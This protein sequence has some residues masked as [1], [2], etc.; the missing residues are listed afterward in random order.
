MIP[1]VPIVE[2]ILL[3]L[4]DFPELNSPTF[5]PDTLHKDTLYLSHSFGVDAICLRS[6]LEDEVDSPESEFVR[7]VESRH[8][9]S[10]AISICN[11][12]LG[13]GLLALSSTNQLAGVELDFRTSSEIP[14]P[15]PKPFDES[16]G[17]SLL[18]AKSM[19]FDKLVT[20]PAFNPKASARSLPEYNRP[21]QTISPQHLR[22]IGGVISQIRKRVETIRS[23]SQLIENR[24]DLQLKEYQR[25]IKLLKEARDRVESLKASGSRERAERLLNSHAVLAT[26]LDKAVVG[27]A[28]LQTSEIGEMEKKWFGELDKMK[29]RVDKIAPRVKQVCSGNQLFSQLCQAA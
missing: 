9:I 8:P 23:A 26:R 28:G 13:Y 18:L 1:V 20:L 16:D 22:V 14:P 7:L 2:S 5:L 11:I 3:P 19:D 15:P 6:W 24:L 29:D 10:G 27:L 4:P 17:S 21:I 12:S 25:Q